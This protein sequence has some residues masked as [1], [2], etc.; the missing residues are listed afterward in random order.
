MNKCTGQNF[1]PLTRAR[2]QTDQRVMQTMMRKALDK[3]LIDRLIN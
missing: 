3:R 2:N 1:V